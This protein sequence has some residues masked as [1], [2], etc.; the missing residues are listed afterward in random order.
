MVP[1]CDPSFFARVTGGSC[2]PAGSGVPAPRAGGLCTK[3][4]VDELAASR[5]RWWLCHPRLLFASG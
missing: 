2:A 4:D 3:S 1:L 5:G